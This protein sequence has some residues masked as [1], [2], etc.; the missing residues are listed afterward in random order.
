[1]A[2]RPPHVTARTRSDTSYFARGALNSGEPGF[3][4]SLPPINGA[5]RASILRFSRSS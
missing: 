1:M 5:S 3:F 2:G 4:G